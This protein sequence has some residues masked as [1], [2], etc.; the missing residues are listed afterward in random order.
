MEKPTVTDQP[1]P[2]TPGPN[3][4][5]PQPQGQPAPGVYTAQ[6]GSYPQQGA[7]PPPPPGYTP[8]GPP[9]PGSAF[10]PNYGATNIII[11]PPII[12]VGACPACR[13]GILEDD[14]TCLGILCAI[15]FFPIGILC[16]L[17]LKN[18]RCSNCGAYFG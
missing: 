18:R 7:Y 9:P 3:P 15:L 4:G 1:P 2:Y 12:A 13:V 10:V 14:F 8:Y 5:G 17:A 11:P 6:P 16:C